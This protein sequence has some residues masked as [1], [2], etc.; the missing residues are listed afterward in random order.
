MKEAI[1]HIVTTVA[2]AVRKVRRGPTYD[3]GSVKVATIKPG[4]QSIIE[5]RG[6][7]RQANKLVGAYRTRRG[8][9]AGEIILF[10]GDAGERPSFYVFDPPSSLFSSVHAGCYRFRENGRYWI[11]FHVEP[12]SIDAGI[13]TIEAQLSVYQGA[14]AC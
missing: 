11:H 6:W 13:Q 4:V 10:G 9:Y 14:K 1:S 12:K 3:N 2:R 8:G 5:A 7:K